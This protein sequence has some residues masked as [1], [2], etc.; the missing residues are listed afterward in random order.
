[1]FHEGAPYEIIKPGYGY[2]TDF[3]KES[4]VMPPGHPEGIYESFANLYR[5]A[6]KAIKNKPIVDGQ[7]PGIEDGVRGMRFIESVV[8]SNKEGNTWIAL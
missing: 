3:A 2:L 8:Q 6:A 1:M 5:G 4:F 7:F